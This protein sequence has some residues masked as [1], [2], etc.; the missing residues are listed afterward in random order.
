MTRSFFAKRAGHRRPDEEVPA[1]I[2]DES[3]AAVSHC[4]YAR[5][6]PRPSPP[7]EGVGTLAIGVLIALHAIGLGLHRD[8]GPPVWAVDFHGDIHHADAVAARTWWKNSSATMNPTQF[9]APHLHGYS[10]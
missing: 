8:L 10:R 5:P 2:T 7:G 1:P 9:G 6:H 3:G 4:Q